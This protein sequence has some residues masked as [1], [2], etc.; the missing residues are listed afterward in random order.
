MTS[1]H[2]LWAIVP[3][4]ATIRVT[5]TIPRSFPHMLTREIWS[6]AIDGV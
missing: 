1:N 3:N 4:M 6:N 5:E 2:L